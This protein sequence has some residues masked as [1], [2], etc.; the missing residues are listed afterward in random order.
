MDVEEKVDSNGSPEIVVKTSKNK[1]TYRIAKSNDGFIFYEIK[2]DIGQL[3]KKLQG[4]YTRMDAA[5]SALLEYLR[6][7]P[8]SKTVERDEK[9]RRA[10]A[11]RASAKDQESVQQ[12]TAN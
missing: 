12:G 5:K 2:P 1:N 4:F 11:S 3:P 9:R 10:V 8:V 6:T 7:A